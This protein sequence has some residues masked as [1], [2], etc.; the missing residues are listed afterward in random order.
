MADRISLGLDIGVASV[1]FS[2]LDI[3]KGKVIELGARLFSAT[4]AAGNQDRRDMRGARRL[5]N[6]NKQRRQDT[7]KLFKKFGLI[8]DF[9]KG[10]FYDNFNQNLNPYELRVKGLTEQLTK[11]E[12][13]ES[14]YQIVKHRG[15]SYALKDADVDEGGTD[16]SV[17]LKINSQELAEKTPAQIQLQRLNDYGKVR[18]QVVIGDDPDNQKVLLNVF[19]TSAYEKEAKQI[20]ATQQQF[21]PESLTDKFTEEY[22]QILTRKRDYFVG[23][24]NEKSRTDY[25]IYKTDGRTLDNLFEEL[26]GHDKIYPEEL[27]ASAASYTAQLF[28]VLNDLNN[29]RILNYE[30]GKLTKEDKEKIIAEIKNNT[31]TINMLNVIKKVAG[32]SKDDIKGFRVNEKDKPEISSMPVYRK[33]HKDLLKAGVDISDWPVEFIDELS[34]ILTL[35]T[36]NG[37]IRKQLNNRLAPKFDFLNA[38]LIQLIIDNKDSFE[39]KTNN[40]WHR[41]SVKTMN[42]LIPEMMERPVEQMTLL[43]EMG[44]VKKDKKRFENNKYLPYKEI[45]KDIFNPVASKSVREALKIVNAVLKK[46]GHIDYLVVEMPRDKNLK[47][48]QDNIKEFQNKNKKA[49]DAAFEAFVKSVGSEQRVKEALSKNRKLQMKMR[50][51]YQQQEIDPYNGK[52]IDATDLINN[53]DKFEI[54]HIIPQSISFDDS[55]NNKTLCFASMNQVKGQKTPYEFM[56]EGHGQSYD[57]FKA[58]VMANKNFGKAKR[59]NYLFEENVSDIETRKRFLSRNLVDTRY[60]SRVVLNSLQD[61]FREKSADTKVTVIR[62]KF[63]SNMR[64]HWH[65]DKTRETFHHHAIDASIIAAT[66]FLRMWKKGGTIFP[67]KV[68]EESID[69]ETGE[70]LDDKNFDKAMYE[71]PYS[72]FVSEI[73]NADDRIKFSHQVDKKMNRKVSDATIYSTRMGRI[74]KDKKDAEY[75][76]DKVKDIYSADGYH[77]KF[78]RIYNKDKTKFLLYKYDPRTFSELERIIADY[79]DKIE[80]V[81]TNGK[82]KPVDIS[83]FELYR[84]DHGMV[85]KYSK[86]GNGPVIKQLKYLD[87][88]LGSHI[89]ITPA[90]AN[91]KHVILQSLKPWRTDVYLNHETGEYEIM[92]IKYSDLKFNKNEGYGIKKD[93]YLEIKKV[94]EVSEKS[95]FMFS[96]YRKDRVKVQ[97]MKTGESVELLFWS[98][99]FSNKKYAELKP[100]SQAENDKKL[101]VYGKGR[102]I[103]RLIPKNCKIWKV[104]TTILGDPYY[105]EKESDSPKDI[106]D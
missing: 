84:R 74:A 40:K 67:V 4:V 59:A 5:L 24:G 97:D 44:L 23:P 62:G 76:I 94:E 99:N 28:N 90:N 57:K 81:Q 82:V 18:G 19:P 92:G 45:A 14:L 104:N 105:L 100:I 53:P 68:G 103:K 2:V 54:D 83:P 51:W 96:L 26:I 86:K 37:E 95:E 49:K 39:I 38:D 10:S 21:Y 69:I 16:Y 80:K 6:R 30:D 22:C 70:I 89:D 36:E 50:L 25:G 17:S 46:Y 98:R 66:P 60:S 56:L 73:M 33:I 55:I 101:P 27:R 7:G 102:L 41:F 3:D 61:F 43:N 8:D 1:G 64:K 58:T 72:G 47:E 79:P 11:E 13:A 29:L 65:I 78:K 93:K 15:I 42:K 34:F 71:E 85:K 48:E 63:T 35:N 87:K 20:V 9:D 32:C 31:T 106:L 77:K 75:I 52:T 88:K 12:L 91:G